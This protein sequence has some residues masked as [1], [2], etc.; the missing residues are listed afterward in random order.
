MSPRAACRLATL[1]YD[2]YDYAPGKVDWMAHARPLEGTDA[3]HPR[4]QTLM[5]GD[6]ATCT[7]DEPPDEVARKID[8]TPYGFALALSPGRVVLGRVRRSRLADAGASIEAVMEP[9]PSTIRP[10]TTIE[11]LATRIARSEARTLV[12]TDPEGELLGVVRRD[13]VE[14]SH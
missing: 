14:G 2:V 3:D 6:V 13:D 10:H 11:D 5:R 1:G 8:A 4:A 9:G 7:L 12:V